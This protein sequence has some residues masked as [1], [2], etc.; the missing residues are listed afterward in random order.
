MLF[1]ALLLFCGGAMNLKGNGLDITNLS[2]DSLNQTVTFDLEWDNS[3]RVDSSGSPWNWDAAWIFVKF[4]PCGAA[5]TTPWTHAKIDPVAGANNWGGLQPHAEGFP[6]GFYP[7]SNGVMLRRPANGIFP[8][9]SS[10]NITFRIDNIPTV[11]QYDVKVFG[12]EMV[13]IV[14]EAFYLGTTNNYYSFNDGSSNPVQITSSAGLTLNNFNSNNSNPTYQNAVLP[15]AYPK[16]YG[17]F[18][19]M[20]YEISE[21][22]YAAFL[23][24]IPLAAALNRYPANYNTY[25][26]RL[27]NNGPPPD[28]YVAEREDRAQNYLSFR[29]LGAYMDWAAL[30][31]MTELEYEK[32]CRGNAPSVQNEYAWGTNTIT[33]AQTI[34][35]AP[36]NG[37]ETIFAPTGANACYGNYNFNGGDGGQ[38]PLRVGIFAR[39]ASNTRI[40][41]GSAFYGVMEMS[42]NVR[43]LCVE[44]R[45]TTYDGTIGD[46]YVDT[47]GDYNEASWPSTGLGFC[48]RGGSFLDATDRLRT[49]DRIYNGRSDYTNRYREVGGRG[50]R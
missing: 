11:G 50:I 40:G 19:V 30:R 1:A 37:T 48:Y 46:G 8:N 32:I 38:G 34:N 6:S 41:T 27:N 26:N 24:T 13:Y 39:P 28:T 2:R 21:G 3:W 49:S 10:S 42:G 12:I 14:E 20:K 47:N 43:E 23:N 4:R 25:R 15:A 45:F 16:G 9:A 17:A 5:S 31:P 29:D 33:Q 22:Q 44:Y 7:D 18:Y 35:T 36:E